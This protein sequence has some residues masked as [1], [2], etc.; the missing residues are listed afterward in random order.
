VH[1]IEDLVVT[2]SLDGCGSSG[3]ASVTVECHSKRTGWETVAD[4]K[5]FVR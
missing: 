1:K 3:Q 2:I 4:D 5:L